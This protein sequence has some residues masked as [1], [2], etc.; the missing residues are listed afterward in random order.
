[1]TGEKRGDTARL[2]GA[3]EHPGI[4]R[5]TGN[6]NCLY[7][8]AAVISM[9][10][11]TLAIAASSDAVGANGVGVSKSPTKAAVKKPEAA[12]DAPDVS[13]NS[14]ASQDKT[15]NRNRS[16]LVSLS[17]L[18]KLRAKKDFSLVDVRSPAEYDRYRIAD[19]I[20][21]PLHQIKTKAFLK[22]MSV[23]LV[24]DGHSTTELQ[25][26]CGELKQAGFD[27]VAVLEGGL[28]A[29][30]ASKRALEGDPVAQSRLNRLSVEELFEARTASNWTV[31]D[32]S[33]Q[34]KSKDIRRWLPAKVTAIPIKSKG[35][36]VARI[37]SVISQQRKRNPQERLLLIADDNEAYERIDVRLKKSGAAPNVLRLDGGVKGYREHVTRQLAIWDQ[38]KQPR[39]Y[40]ACSG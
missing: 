5:V 10:F 32:V 18:D 2:R 17:A 15:Y 33:T 37:S 9:I 20:N 16:C 4:V 11:N 39:K 36:P 7:F 28:F 14:S 30:Q 31:I 3:G 26:T 24:N 38:Q 19:S 35:D 6:V 23:V 12:C 22:K 29:W 21:I 34:G 40:Q 8:A 25:K 1:M 27:R 13:K